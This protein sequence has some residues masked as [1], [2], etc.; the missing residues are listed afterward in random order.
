MYRFLPCAALALMLLLPLHALAASP[1]APKPEG[2]EVA[3]FAGGCF[4]CVEADFDY[5][6][7]VVSTISGYT[8]GSL[9]NP[10]YRQVAGGRT[11]HI[12]A[13][14]IHYDPK[15]VSYTGLLD[16]LWRSIDP[17]DDGGQ[18]CDRGQSYKTA[19]FA[20]SA[21]QKKLAE[22]SKLNL[23]ESGVLKAP[24]VTE[25][26]AA[27]TFYPAEDYHQNYYRKNPLRYKFYRYRC[28]RD[29]RI[30]AL[31]GS[32]AMQGITKQ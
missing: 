25:I 26:V 2:L 4:W 14:Q 24:V 15:K 27:S 5:V 29:A 19:I 32:Q 28:G 8:G 21:A 7:G 31:W 12:E 1:A 30:E 20:N 17:T 18:F 6:P 13:V 9:E 11:R 23:A 3:T 10:T 16:V 22:A